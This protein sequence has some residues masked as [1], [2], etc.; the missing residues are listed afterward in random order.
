MAGW[1]RPSQSRI[2][3]QEC[4][5]NWRPP[6]PSCADD[7][8]SPGQNMG[9]HEIGTYGG[10]DRFLE[11]ERTG[12]Q[13]AEDAWYTLASE[14]EHYK[15]CGE[16]FVGGTADIAKC[17]DQIS[18]ILV[19]RLA[20]EA[21]MPLEIL[22]AYQRYQENLKV[23]N[24]IA[25]GIGKAFTRKCGIPQGC[26][27]SMMFTSL[28]MRP[29]ILKVKGLSDQ[30]VPNI[31]A[32]D[33]LVV[34]HGSK[35]D[36][37]FVKAI[38]ETHTYIKTMGGKLAEGKSQIFASNEEHR[39]WF[40]KST[41]QGTGGNIEVVNDMRYLGA[42]L[43]VSG[44]RKATTCTAR[45]K[46][47]IIQLGK[48]K[49]LP[50]E[51]KLK[52]KTIRTKVYPKVFYGVE[53]V[54]IPDKQ[55]ATRSAAVIKV[56][57]GEGS[58]H[59]VDS[60]YATCSQGDDIDPVSQILV[61]C[62]MTLRRALAKRP[63]KKAF[64]QQIFHIYQTKGAHGTTLSSDYDAQNNGELKDLFPAPH[65][66][67][68]NMSRAAWM[69]GQQ[70]EGPVGHLIRAV[71]LCGAKINDLFEIISFNE[72]PIGILD[73]PYQFLTKA[74]LAMTA[75][76]RT[77]A[78]QGSRALNTFLAEIDAKA[79]QGMQSKMD[80]EDIGYIHLVQSAA[81]WGK[82]SLAAIGAV[83]SDQCDLCGEAKHDNE[84][85]IW[86]CKTLAPYRKI[87]DSEL[88]AINPKYLHKDI[89]RGIAPA[90]GTQPS[91]SY[92]GGIIDEALSKE[93]KHLLGQ[94]HPPAECCEA[95]N[96]LVHAKDLQCNARQLIAVCRGGFG[97]GGTPQ[98]PEAVHGKA[99]DKPDTFSDG[100]VKNPS[101]QAWS[102]G[103]YGVW[104]K[105]AKESTAEHHE[106]S[107]VKY[108]HEREA[109]QGIARW[110]P[111]AGFAT[112]ST[113]NELAA[114]ILAL[115]FP[116][117]VHIGSDSKAFVDK[118]NYLLRAAKK[119]LIT[120]GTASHNVRNP[121][122]KPWAMQTDGDLWIIFWEAILIRGPDSSAFTW[123]KG[124][125]T[126][127]DIA[128]GISNATLKY[129]NDQSDIAATNGTAAHRAGLLALCRWA[130][131]RHADYVKFTHKVQV[132]IVLMCR[133]EKRIRHEKKPKDMTGKT[134]DIKMKIHKMVTYGHNDGA[135]NIVMIPCPVGNHKF[136]SMQGKVEA[137]H[138]F[139]SSMRW[140]ERSNA[141]R[142][143]GTSWLE[144]L[145]MFE[146][147]GF[148]PELCRKGIKPTHTSEKDRTRIRRWKEFAAIKKKKNQSASLLSA[149]PEEST[150]T[151]L[152]LFK[153]IFRFIINHCCAD[154]S[155]HLFKQ[156]TEYRHPRFACYAIEGH[157]PTIDAAISIDCR[158][159]AMINKAVLHQRA[160]TG[161]HNGTA[162]I[163]T[164]NFMIN[165]KCGACINEAR[166]TRR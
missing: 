156:N 58:K 44:K 62:C 163:N 129:G 164:F 77:K 106:D 60:T 137:V 54:K 55:L 109:D 134:I 53:V 127:V 108:Y 132:F 130:A 25:K 102:L 152:D 21:G 89:K 64:F 93:L 72:A 161:N 157:T 6:E 61:R 80:K 10:M 126:D 122:G 146:L 59:D 67:R 12:N 110:G 65:P 75:R 11:H 27:L 103:G 30:I 15:L 153:R 147:F 165:T 143:S 125:V 56:I 48:L 50:I 43:N 57:S 20:R 23:H 17:F 74:V 141:E 118:A 88:A 84:H 79:T 98:F 35:C 107:L 18:R 139:I 95:R 33:I 85:S 136:S 149:A 113:R 45:I 13:G 63:Q 87:A 31:L 81:A 34:A 92:W 90:M 140:T 52:A 111:L 24:T 7:Y 124:H 116:R 36:G 160:G 145:M 2:P 120:F 91:C 37:L 4:F 26:P 155:Q 114:A 115:M 97:Q 47:G 150:T 166:E 123:V 73:T 135:A 32:D 154:D 40:K 119:W 133:E 83:E 68:T 158:Q 99:K 42:H 29:W 148:D 51:K 41:W 28:I 19:Y 162:I 69:G 1:S 22:S 82:E 131:R 144:L 159:I 3:H 38:D 78:A 76:C 39:D 49:K 104:T 5:Q 66:S 9:I 100:G 86:E 94:R 16:D 101:N 46:G 8:A 128:N 71:H 142:D 14:V 121:M 117:P 70:A 151:V 112:S 105:E 138:N 96:I